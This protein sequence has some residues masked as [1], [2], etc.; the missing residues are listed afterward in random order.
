VLHPLT[1]MESKDLRGRAMTWEPTSI[2]GSRPAPSSPSFRRVDEGRDQTLKPPMHRAVIPEFLGQSVPLG[3]GARAIDNAVEDLAE[4]SS[5]AA[6]FLGRV[7][8]RQYCRDSRPKDIGNL[9]N[10]RKKN[11]VSFRA[12]E[13]NRHVSSM[14]ATGRCRTAM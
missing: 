4:T 7:C 12:G 2:P 14:A 5:G 3:T 8:L 11:G 6:C 13:T 1:R 9:P 10:G